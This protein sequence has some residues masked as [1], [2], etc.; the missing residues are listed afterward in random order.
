M[1]KF[2]CLLN[3]VF[4]ALEGICQSPS[5]VE[6]LYSNIFDGSAIVSDSNSIYIAGDIIANCL[7]VKTDSSLHPLWNIQIKRPSNGMSINSLLLNGNSLIFTGYVKDTI[8]PNPSSNPYVL[9][10]GI[11]DTLTGQLVNS[12]I[13]GDSLYSFNYSTIQT[14]DGNFL[15]VGQCQF[16]INDPNPSSEGLIIKFDELLNI[17]WAKRYSIGYK[18]IFNDAIDISNNY[19]I[20]GYIEDSTQLQDAIVLKIDSIGNTSWC[21]VLDANSNEN[22]N[23]IIAV[24]DTLFITGEAD[25]DGFVCAL[26]TSCNFYWNYLFHSNLPLYKNKLLSYN[27]EFLLVSAART[28]MKLGFDG[29]LLNYNQTYRSYDDAIIQY[30]NLLT[31][32]AGQLILSRIDT[33]LNMCFPASTSLQ[34]FPFTFMNSSISFIEQPFIYNDLGMVYDSTYSIVDSLL[35]ETFT[36]ITEISFGVYFQVSPNPARDEIYLNFRNNVDFHQTLK[37]E[38]FDVLGKQCLTYFG[39][40]NKESIKLDISKLTN[41]IYYLYSPDFGFIE[42]FVKL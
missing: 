36:D 35:C 8:Q 34:A 16:D 11:V 21:N 20:C 26:D 18:T 14:S 19:F 6:K 31:V 24:N 27:N 28:I 22:V 41:G 15:S 38:I 13:I 5:T 29:S 39:Q 42:K 3:L 37:I 1:L 23:S 40:T 17:I 4:C 32:N 25:D 30:P 12:R 10:F 9:M 7:I 2:I 33:T